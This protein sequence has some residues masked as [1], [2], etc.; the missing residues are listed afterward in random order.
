VTD[1]GA[2]NIRIEFDWGYSGD[3]GSSGVGFYVFTSSCS[4][5][6]GN[7]WGEGDNFN[8]WVGTGHAVLVAKLYS[9][10]DAVCS[11]F[12]VTFV[13]EAH[14]SEIAPDEG[15]SWPIVTHITANEAG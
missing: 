8:G 13:T 3:Y 2:D 15:E 1:L 4:P 12:E 10:T 9:S 11:T 5:A 6:P 7:R 14:P